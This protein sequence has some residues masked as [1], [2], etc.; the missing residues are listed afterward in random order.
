MVEVSIL[1]DK[2]RFEEKSLYEKAQ[3]KGI[4]SEIVDAKTVSVGT[5][6]KKRISI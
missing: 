3:N 1:C 4:K 5:Y 2:V 6:S